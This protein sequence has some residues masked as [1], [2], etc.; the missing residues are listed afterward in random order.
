MINLVYKEKDY[1][2]EFGRFD[3]Y[4]FMVPELGSKRI[5]VYAVNI[6]DTLSPM[7]RVQFG[8]L[9]GFL[10]FGTECD[11]Y[12]QWKSSLKK[13]QA[14]GSGIAILLVDDDG[15]GI[16]FENKTKFL[17][18]QN[19]LNKPPI[20][21]ARRF[22]IKYEDFSSFVAIPYILRYLK[23][24]KPLI[25]LSNSPQKKK[26]LLDLGVKILKTIPLFEKNGYLE[27]K[28][29]KELEEKKQLLGHRLH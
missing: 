2:T 6:S 9:Y 4:H 14:Y 25:L 5:F 20:Y 26:S 22:H 23:V 11:C 27:D 19:R 13:I 21:T 1:G 10:S 17:K 24:T 29:I 12:S 8:C 16:G 18:L 3:F 15:R 7:V 28:A